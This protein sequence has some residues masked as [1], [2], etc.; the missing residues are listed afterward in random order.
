MANILVVDDARVMRVTIVKQLENM[1]HF[2]VAEAEN[3]YEAIK[4]Y[5]EHKPDAV[6]MDI[7]MP[8]VNGVQ[9]G[10]EALEQIK[11]FDPDAKV[12]MLTS[13]GEQKLVI[14]AISKGSKGYVLKP[15]TQAKLSDVLAKINI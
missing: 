10:I 4:K 14:K 7:S 5:K 2:I 6:T 9:D 13:H 8:G 12:I 1:G 3:G 11:S 15:V